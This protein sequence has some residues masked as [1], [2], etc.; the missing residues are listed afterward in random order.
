MRRQWS[1]ALAG[2]TVVAAMAAC[3]KK[4]ENTSATTVDASAAQPA[5]PAPAEAAPAAANV[6]LPPGVTPEMVAAGRTI[7]H[8]TGNCF[9]CHGADGKGTPLA[10]DQTDDKWLNTDGSYD[11]IVKVITTG[12]PVPKDKTHPSPMPPKGGSTITDQ[13]VKEVAAYIYS[14]S[15]GGTP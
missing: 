7:Y 1:V 2:L 11:G 12:V 9:T 8:S 15:H 14:I 5:A 10:P 4:E 6:Q 3:S 13:Q